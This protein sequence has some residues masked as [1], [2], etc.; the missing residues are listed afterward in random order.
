MIEYNKFNKGKGK[1]RQNKRNTKKSKKIKKEVYNQKHIRK[2]TSL[3][4]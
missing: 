4:S 2:V 1:M 3:K